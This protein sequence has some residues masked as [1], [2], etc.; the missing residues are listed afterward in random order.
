MTLVLQN[1]TDVIYGIRQIV[2]Y[3][4]AQYPNPN[5]EQIKQ[6]E[7]AI[8]RRIYRLVK[9]ALRLTGGYLDLD[10]SHEKYY[11]A[12]VR[13]FD[14]HDNEVEIMA[15]FHLEASM[16]NRNNRSGLMEPFYLQ[17]VR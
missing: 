13:A 5:P 9:E 10:R 15:C 14:G 7:A 11:Y 8:D 3:T 17:T 16:L 4:N 12:I 1:P 6:R 2:G